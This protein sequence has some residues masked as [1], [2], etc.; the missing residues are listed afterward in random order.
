[1]SRGKRGNK[2]LY[3]HRVTFYPTYLSPPARELARN[4]QIKNSWKERLGGAASALGELR[5]YFRE[6]RG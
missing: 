2:L 3:S 6:D 4:I 5:S 1:M